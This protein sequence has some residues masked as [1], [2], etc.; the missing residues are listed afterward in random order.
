MTGTARRSVAKRGREQEGKRAGQGGRG[1][2]RR[3]SKGGGGVLCFGT[4]S[5]AV[6]AVGHRI[7]HLYFAPAAAYSPFSR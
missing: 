7:L 3:A 4:L 6:F 1:E 2:G 5:L